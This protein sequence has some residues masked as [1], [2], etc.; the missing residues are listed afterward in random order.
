MAHLGMGAANDP[1]IWA[2][3]MP[4]NVLGP[5]GDSEYHNETVN[6]RIEF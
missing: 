1:L 3:H 6:L 5:L 2:A 4:R